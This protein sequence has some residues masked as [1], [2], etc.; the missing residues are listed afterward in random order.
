MRTPIFAL[1]TLTVVLAAPILSTPAA[2]TH[3]CFGPDCGI[4]HDVPD[5][6][7]RCRV[8]PGDPV[9]TIHVCLKEALP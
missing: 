9:R 1:L 4:P 8:Y 5:E 6:L 7:P 3:P 2:A